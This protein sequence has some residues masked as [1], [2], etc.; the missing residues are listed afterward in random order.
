[1]VFPISFRSLKEINQ[2]PELDFN[3]QEKHDPHTLSIHP[4]TNLFQKCYSARSSYDRRNRYSQIEESMGGSSRTSQ[5]APDDRHND[6]HVW[7]LAPNLQYHDGNYG[8][9]E[10]YHGNVGY[11]PGV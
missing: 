9:Q 2:T 11:E 1:M 8:I 7:Q 6:V 10:S 4:E 5:A 3:C